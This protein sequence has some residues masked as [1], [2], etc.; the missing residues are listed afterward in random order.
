MSDVIR[1][2]V[3]WLGP[4]PTDSEIREFDQRMLTLEFDPSNV[5]SLLPTF[6]GIIFKYDP[7]K[8]GYLEN[9]IQQLGEQAID[10]GILLSSV[11][12][13]DTSYTII[14]QQLD[15]LGI[16]PDLHN[17]KTLPPT[18]YLAETIARHDPG[19]A[20]SSLGL[21]FQEDPSNI[22][23]PDDTDRL[24]LKRAF[25]DCESILLKRLEGG[26]TDAKVYSAHV[27]FRAS[28]VGPRPLPFFV[29]IDTREKTEQ[30]LHRYKTFA[31]HFINF[32][33]R[34]NV[35]K[36]RSF[37]GFKRG[38]IVGDFVEQSD[39][40]WNVA[41]RGGAQQV[42]NTLFDTTLRGWR[43]QNVESRGNLAKVFL[44]ELKVVNHD[45]I[46]EGRRR[47]ARDQGA[48]K[49]PDE[50][51]A[52]IQSLSDRKYLVG[53]IHSDLHAKNVRV[54]NLDAILIDF[55]S[56]RQGP[57]MADPACL[58]VSLSIGM[59]NHDKDDAGW[60]RVMHSLYRL[61]YVNAVPPLAQEPSP[62]EWL[63]TCVR[64]IRLNALAMQVDDLE[65]AIALALYLMRWATFQEKHSLPDEHD[66]YRKAHAYVL[67]ERL[68][69]EMKEL[70]CG[71]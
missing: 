25:C 12:H 36:Q 51:L 5:N 13:D 34:P 31:A 42:L 18:H 39:T 40:L 38:I 27:K 48:T 66:E 59:D 23:S 50:L 41:K 26:H 71:K 64:Q 55:Y 19:P 8:P 2:R 3:L 70:D 20:P 7:D 21:I 65:Y 56:A 28:K 22:G 61:D 63:W 57:L 16:S 30:E 45:W 43:M 11:A 15:R 58:E 67:A 60:S 29:K 33:L 10:H 9:A 46:P 52:C 53:P 37:V 35:D 6:R 47:L 69:L 4:K 1:N 24:F 62:R 49:N 14:K 54:R 68:I 44:N 32:H 17:L